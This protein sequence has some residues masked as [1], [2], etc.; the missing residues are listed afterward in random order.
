MLDSHCHIDDDKLIEER[1]EVI[2]NA[3]E[4][5]VNLIMTLGTDLE[6]SKSCVKIANEFEGVYAAVGFH[7]QNLE[8][9]SDKA[10]EEIKELAKDKKVIAIGEVGLD[11][12]WFKD[13]KDREFQKVW[14]N[15]QI[16]IAN[17][18]NLPL[19]IHA[20]DAEQ[21][22]YDLLKNNFPKAGCVLHCFSGSTEMMEQY[23]KLGAYIGF[24]GPITYKNSIT[25]K[26]NV[27]RCPLDRIL[28]E[29]DSPYLAP[30]PHRGERNEP[31]YIPLILEEMAQLKGL[32]KE[33]ME[34]VVFENFERLFKVS[35]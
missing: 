2:K 31:K 4:A 27:R 22:T 29:T 28:T 32:S 20:R 14:F 5:G 35:K 18:L 11:Y 26:E 24:D 25:P 19:S 1:A 34:R 10:L 21:D 15:K 23:L 8:N 6:S 16:E 30:V 33:E 13:P 3:K 12:H 7:P 17:E 9:V